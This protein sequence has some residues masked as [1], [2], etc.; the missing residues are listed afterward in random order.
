MTFGVSIL[1]GLSAAALLLLAARSAVNG[2]GAALYDLLAAGGCLAV[3]AAALAVCYFHARQLTGPSYRVDRDKLNAI[4][5]EAV[6]AG[7]RASPV[8]EALSG[9]GGHLREGRSVFD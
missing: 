7:G 5:W 9:G 4:R 1:A 3:G 6:G 8:W 2:G